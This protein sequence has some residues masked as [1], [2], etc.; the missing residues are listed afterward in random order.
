MCFCFVEL[1]I[2]KQGKRQQAAIVFH[3]VCITF[4][5]RQLTL[6]VRD[7]QK[8]LAISLFLAQPA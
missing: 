5:S 2:H 7:E 4:L 6:L 3:V 1:C 8:L